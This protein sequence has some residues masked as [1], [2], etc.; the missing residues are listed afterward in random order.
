MSVLSNRSVPQSATGGCRSVSSGSTSD[1]G[2]L[3]QDHSPG[4]NS[5]WRVARLTD[6]ANIVHWA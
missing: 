4:N 3:D 6:G 5:Q 1:G 2:N